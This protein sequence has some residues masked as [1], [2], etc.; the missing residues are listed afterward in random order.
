MKI[1]HAFKIILCIAA[2][3]IAPLLATGLVR[4]YP[5]SPAEKEAPIFTE[6]PAPEA[7]VTLMPTPISAGFGDGWDELTSAAETSAEETTPNPDAGPQ[8]YPQS[9]EK[10]DGKISRTSYSN[11][12]GSQIFNLEN[13]GQVRNCTSVLSPVLLK[14]SVQL[15]DYRLSPESGE[16]QVLIVHTHTTESFEPYSRDFYDASFGSRTTDGTRNM[17]MVGNEVAAQLETAGISVIHDTTIHDYPSYNGSYSRSE[18]TVRAALK[19]YPSIKIVLD[20]HRDAIS[21]GNTRFAP[22]ADIGGKSA[23][24]IMIIS[25]CDKNGN[26]PNYMQ[27]FRLACHIQQQAE[28]DYPGFTRPILFDYRAYNQNLSP[29]SLLIEIGS[30]ANS[31]DEARYSGELLG[32]TLSHSLA[33]LT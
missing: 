2:I 32:K 8:P 12:R 10:N 20:L 14:Q 27:N 26:I 33:A 25:C 30:S 4:L 5:D 7:A 11:L 9:I 21:S 23:A 31:L 6:A 19:K 22:V 29:G 18:Q 28:T 17:V 15:P 13:G 3:G 24:Q 16:P 1:K